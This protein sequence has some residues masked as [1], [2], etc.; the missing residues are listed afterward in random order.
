MTV[1]REGREGETERKTGVGER[2]KRRKVNKGGRGGD[3]RGDTTLFRDYKILCLKQRCRYA[4]A[5]NE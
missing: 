2:V 4:G 1:G 5:N 3:Y